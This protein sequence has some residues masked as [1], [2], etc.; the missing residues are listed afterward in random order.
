MNNFLK[1]KFDKPENFCEIK[2]VMK[3]TTEQIQIVKDYKTSE[4][5]GYILPGESCVLSAE[6]VERKRCLPTET[7]EN[8]VLV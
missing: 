6:Y 4:V 2:H 3:N 8:V 1:I 7:P 5:I